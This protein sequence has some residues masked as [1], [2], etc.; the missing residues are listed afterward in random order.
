VYGPALPTRADLAAAAREERDTQLR[1][2]T[3]II[4]S[5]RW[6]C[7][8]IV[9]LYKLYIRISPQYVHNCFHLDKN[10]KRAKKKLDVSERH[11]CPHCEY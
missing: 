8:V 9:C 7:N 11:E 2:Y 10:S 5:H 3:C 1:V 6:K 4:F